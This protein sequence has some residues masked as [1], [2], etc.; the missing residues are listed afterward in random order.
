[1]TAL[2]LADELGTTDRTLRRLAELGTIRSDGAGGGLRKALPLE[3]SYLR[4]HWQLLSRLREALRTEPRVTAALLFGSVAR[5]DDTAVSDVDLVVA[6]EGGVSSRDLRRL[7]TRLS[8]K[9]ERAVDLFNLD[10]LLGEPERLG[11]VLDE[12][13][14]V[15]DRAL[16]W[17]QLRVL[18]RRWAR[19]R[20]R[21]E[22]RT[23]R[24]RQAARST[25][26]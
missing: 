16:V 21:S 6:L 17:P 4:A 8:R 23:G 1:V 10:D 11:P 5:G 9:V 25:P 20:G 22:R 24:V 13:R 3:E 2:G 15:V 12:G 7:S 14:P 26:A 19:S 18:R